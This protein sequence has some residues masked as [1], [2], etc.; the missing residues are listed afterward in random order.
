M[1][2]WSEYEEKYGE[3]R[4]D[5]YEEPETSWEQSEAD[6]AGVPLFGPI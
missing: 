5:F 2:T 6:A 4:E 3:I 1:I